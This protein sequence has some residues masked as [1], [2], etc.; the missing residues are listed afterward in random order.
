MPRTMFQIFHD[1]SDDKYWYTILKLSLIHISPV[2]QPHKRHNFQPLSH[3][4]FPLW[5]LLCSYK[6]MSHQKLSLH[7]S[8][9]IHLITS[10]FLCSFLIFIIPHQLSV[11]PTSCI[12]TSGCPFLNPFSYI[13]VLNKWKET[14]KLT[15]IILGT[16]QL[17]KISNSFI[18]FPK[19][20]SY[21]TY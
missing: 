13:L 16:S 9:P 14:K 4:F 8:Y 2:F 21:N 15:L 17:Q 7:Q 18:F 20:I 1:K 6:E 11:C 12:V 10:K 3:I 19:L 5:L